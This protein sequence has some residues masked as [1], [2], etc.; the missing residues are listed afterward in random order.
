MKN[1]DVLNWYNGLE[2]KSGF[3]IVSQFKLLVGVPTF[4][5]DKAVLM[6]I[7]RLAEKVK[8][9]T[10]N[11]NA[12]LKTFLEEIFV[13]PSDAIASAAAACE[14]D[15]ERTLQAKVITLKAD[16]KNLKRK[17]TSF[18]DLKGSFET[19]V[20]E[21]KALSSNLEECLKDK[22]LISS[23]LT[24]IKETYEQK[25]EELHQLEEKFTALK[26]RSDDKTVRLR[27]EHKKLQRRD[28]T[29]T[30]DKEKMKEKEKEFKMTVNSLNKKIKNL[31]SL[32]SDIRFKEAS[33]CGEKESLRKK[34]IYMR[35]KLGDKQE[36][37][38]EF[39][40][41]DFLEMSKECDDL[42]KKVKNL[43][44]ENRDLQE[45]VSLLEDDEIVTFH[46]GKYCNEIREVVMRLLSL[47]VSMRNIDDVIRCVLKKLVNKDICR[48]PSIAVKS[49]IQEEA[50][51]LAQIQV[52]EAMLNETSTTNCLHG[53]GTSKYHKHYQNFQ[54]TTSE[55][56][57]LSFGL[58]E[59]AGGDAGMIF[60]NFTETVEDLC[61]V[62]GTP[63]SDTD[64]LFSKLISN[65]RSTMSD[66]G[67]VNPL[68]NEKLKVLRKELLP[69]AIKNWNE[70]S[71][72]D[73]SLLGEM[74]NFFC[75]LH[76]L[77]NFATEGDK[78][79]N[80]FEKF[81]LCDDYETVFA[82]NTKE[83]GAARLVRTACKAFHVRGSD[84]AGVASYFNSFLAGQDQ[85]SQF[86]S[87][88]GNRFNILF[89]NAA[90][91]YY[92]RHSVL[93]FVK[94]WPNPN[95]LLKAVAEDLSNKVFCAEVR[96][97]GIIDKLLTGP[98][99]RLIEAKNSILELNSY[100]F[101]LKLRLSDLCK[102]S[103]S[104]LHGQ[105]VFTLPDVVVHDNDEVYQSLF[106]EV[107][108]VC[109]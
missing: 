9:L 79:L 20:I 37:I 22:K 87:F 29:I 7:K 65:I 92:H 69:N 21:M 40:G 94:S 53:D 4:H 90:A 81:V 50:L 66:Q 83:S 72:D 10:K 103:S 59:V 45:L 99:W 42:A 8:K 95:N 27:N 34:L 73:Q 19:K 26:S 49:R 39:S 33:I 18:D 80:V 71:A 12:E 44:S 38:D 2:D 76:L 85:T 28:S 3:N 97:L 75:K 55:G 54:I 47:N 106:E 109:L 107:L 36:L 64:D 93:K 67:P 51:I 68:F 16:C 11:K 17:V 70:L 13:L 24:S 15:R 74:G 6:K 63:N 88:I 91:L 46:D 108:L 100:I 5:S 84:E 89:Y 104:L 43:N 32:V 96:A 31:E 41:K 48:L 57:T 60:N 62:L 78:V 52:G 98:L 30:K 58:S 82:F 105:K 86:A 101:H 1:K 14:T 23:E 56:K 35:K 77:A 102:D 61:K 25:S